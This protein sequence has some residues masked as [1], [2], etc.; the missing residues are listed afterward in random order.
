[1]G[2]PG[3]AGRS[4]SQQPPPHQS[5]EM[6]RLM[7]GQWAWGLRSVPS[8]TQTPRKF[9]CDLEIV[10]GCVLE[11]C[12]GSGA[13]AGPRRLKL[14]GGRLDIRKDFLAGKDGEPMGSGAMLLT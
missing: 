5:M 7:E 4:G 14:E 9:Q 3:E 11:P 10:S 8:C 2:E 12:A 13:F 6:E 1:M